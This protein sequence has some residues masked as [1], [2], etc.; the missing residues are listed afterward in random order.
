MSLESLGW[1]TSLEEFFEPYRLNGFIPARVTEEH[2]ERYLILCEHGERSAEVTG[3]LRFTATSRLDFPTV[4]DW[5]AVQASESDDLAVIHALLPRK[6]VFLRKVAGETTEPQPVAANV[7]TVLIVTDTGT[8]FSLR[9]MERYLTLVYESGAVPVIVLN[10]ADMATNVEQ[11]MV[12]MESAAAGVPIHAV[13]ATTGFGFDNLA[14]LVVA[15]KTVALI[16]SSGVGKST[17]INRLLGEE[18]I[19]TNEVREWDG[20]GRHTTTSR[21]MILLPTGGIVIDTPGMKEI[22]LWG[23]EES[24]AGAFDDIERLAG[25]CR[26]ADCTHSTEPGCAVQQ[27]LADGGLDAA[28]Y[29]SYLKLKKELRYLETRQSAS[30]AQAEKT[31]WK[32]IHKKAK[33]IMKHKYGRK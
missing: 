6:T 25:R 21:Q 1:D 31:K 19:K 3:K 16:G 17:I 33:E 11:Q 7:E 14:S 32:K 27:A 23:N 10:K 13:S 29:G 18:R 22:Q 12:E 30:A 20:R 24:L 8:D 5:V 26:F 4:G 28:R 15:G 2:R 9:R